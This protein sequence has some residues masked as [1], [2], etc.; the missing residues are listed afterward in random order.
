[1]VRRMARTGLFVSPAVLAGLWA[2]GGGRAALSGL[3]GL[4]M[5][6]ANLWL[7]ARVIGGVA[8]TTPQLLVLAAL[9]AF[10]LGLV[11]LTAVAL[12]LQAVG[13]VS[14]GVAGFTL[15]GAHLGLV[16]WEAR[17]AFPVGGAASREGASRVRR[18]AWS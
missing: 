16:L 18:R 14:F 13:V 2:W 4:A 5:A 10:G 17:R 3:V 1:M 15:I 11:A 8:D 6:L 7:A 9:A 12:A